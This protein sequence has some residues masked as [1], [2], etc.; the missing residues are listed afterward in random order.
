M[1]D[2][3]LPICIKNRNNTY[4]AFYSTSGQY[5]KI[6]I[7]DENQGFYCTETIHRVRLYETDS[8]EEIINKNNKYIK[9]VLLE[10][11]HTEV[12]TF[13]EFIDKIKYVENINNL[14]CKFSTSDG[15]GDKV[16]FEIDKYDDNDK[17]KRMLKM[18]PKEKYS[19]KHIT[20]DNKF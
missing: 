4:F 16:Y 13:E 17:F 10:C 2:I 18:A 3:T 5:C 7:I 20:E 15:T 12:I 19:F 9:E 6:I 14:W 11:Q 1:K 8:E